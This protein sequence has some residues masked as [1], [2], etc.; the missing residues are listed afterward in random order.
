MFFIP[1]ALT[2]AVNSMLSLSGDPHQAVSLRL[3]N[4]ILDVVQRE[5]INSEVRDEERHIK[6]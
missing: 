5:R 2:A 6:K 3:S 4:S 1:S